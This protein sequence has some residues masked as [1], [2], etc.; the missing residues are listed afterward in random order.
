MI[1]KDCSALGVTYNTDGQL[2]A[3]PELPASPAVPSSLAV[4]LTGQPRSFQLAYSQWISGPLLPYLRSLGTIDW[5]VVATRSSSYN[6]TSTFMSSLSVT[7]TFL[8]ENLE[9]ADTGSVVSEKP[10][11]GNSKAFTAADVRLNVKAIAEVGCNFSLS[12]CHAYGKCPHNTNCRARGVHHTSA[13]QLWQ[14]NKCGELITSHERDRGAQYVHAARLR[15][16]TVVWWTTN[17]D[18]EYERERCKASRQHGD[19]SQLAVRPATELGVAGLYADVATCARVAMQELADWRQAKC[20]LP[21]PS[22]KHWIAKFQDAGDFMAV[23]SRSA[24]VGHHFQTLSFLL[25]DSLHLRVTND[26]YWEDFD[27]FDDDLMW[28]TK[29]P[30]LLATSHMVLSL[31][32]LPCELTA[33]PLRIRITSPH[34]PGKN[35]IASARFSPSSLVGN[36]GDAGGPYVVQDGIHWAE[37]LSWADDVHK[38]TGAEPSTKLT[39]KA[40]GY[41]DNGNVHDFLHHD[42]WQKEDR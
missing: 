27:W 36:E 17:E 1:A 16:D 20:R 25:A 33:E 37:F 31:A 39:E 32:T 19:E 22:E 23:G 21:L 38:C 9:L 14:L 13:L 2:V 10:R 42:G 26:T 12:I 11:S 6:A 24:I 5:F 18:A 41:G 4:C 3:M 30:T 28:L 35:S 8:V 40:I 29:L 7:K 15:L 34:I